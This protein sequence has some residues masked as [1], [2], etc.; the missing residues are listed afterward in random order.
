MKKFLMAILATLLALGLMGSSIAYFNDI[1]TSTSNTFT[2]GTLGLEVGDWNEDFGDGVS[3]TWTM[4]NMTP[5]VTTVGPLS[6]TIRNAG[7]LLGDH[8]EVSFSHVIDEASNPVP[9]DTNP[10]STAGEMARWLEITQMTYDTF[11]FLPGYTDANGNGF[12]DLED[13]TMSPYTD[14][15]GPLDDL[16]APLAA[17][18][19]QL[20]MALKLNA[21]AT[22]E[23]QGDIL[24]T[25]VTFTLNQ[26]SSQ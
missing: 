6:V 15:G 19:R 16:P 26:H 8:V 3:A 2:A 9:S 20:T 17:G 22:D 23:I 12:F 14:A 4:S 11:D 18:F 13:L 10:A 1:E 24:I 21:G 7:S 25:T 5:G